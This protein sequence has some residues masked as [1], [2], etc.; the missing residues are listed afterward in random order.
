MATVYCTWDAN[1]SGH[2]TSFHFMSGKHKRPT[3]MANTP[4]G[5]KFVNKKF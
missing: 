4:T 1:D 5:W 2:F 3:P